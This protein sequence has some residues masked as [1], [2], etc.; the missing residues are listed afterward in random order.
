MKR[1]RILS[2]VLVGATVAG[3]VWAQGGSGPGEPQTSPMIRQ[4]VVASPRAALVAQVIRVEPT[5]A[6]PIDDV[7]PVEIFGDVKAPPDG[8]PPVR[9]RSIGDANLT[10]LHTLAAVELTQRSIAVETTIAHFEG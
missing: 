7:F 5:N 6:P 4:V 1:S 3:S 9:A 2:T 8:E 10:S